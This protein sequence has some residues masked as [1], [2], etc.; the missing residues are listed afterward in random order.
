[1]NRSP[2]QLSDHFDYGRLVSFTLPTVLMMLLSSIFGVVDGIFVSNFAGTETYSGATAFAAVNLVWPVPMVLGSIGYMFGIGGCALVSKIRGEGDT[3]RANGYFTMILFVSAVIGL[4]MSGLGLLTIE[5]F[6]NL[7]GGQGVLLE[8]ALEYGKTLMVF[9]PFFV[10]Q[11]TFL[12]FL[13]SAEDPKFRLWTISFAGLANVVLDVLLIWELKMS[14]TGAAWATSISWVIGGLIPILYFIIKRRTPLRIVRNFCLWNWK[15]LGK[16]C[17]NGVSEFVTNLSMSVVNLLCVYQLMRIE[18]ELGVAAYGVIMYVNVV[19]FAVYSGFVMGSSPIISYHY[20]ANNM[21]EVNNLW[22]KS[23]TLLFISAIIV[24]FA[25]VVLAKPIANLY[26]GYDSGL[27]DLTH[28]AFLIYSLSFILTPF[29]I[30]GSAFFTALNNGKVSALIA[31]SRT[32]LFQAL[33]VMILPIEWGTD[34]VWAALPTAELV[35]LTLTILFFTRLK[36]K[37]SY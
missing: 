6:A 14:V 34:G 4:L 37:Y 2:I 31:F 7:L 23:V 29:N 10:L 26:A 30:Y 21:K 25:A 27:W 20:G 3:E 9:L 35:S 16:A 28:R 5:S 1:M 33:A 36:A 32:L 12:P 13:I 18:G 22:H 17:T 11:T 15:A 19:F 24:M 8:L